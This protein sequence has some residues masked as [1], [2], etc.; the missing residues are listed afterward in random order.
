LASVADFG[1]TPAPGVTRRSR[2]ATHGAANAVAQRMLPQKLRTGGVE[3]SN[4]ADRDVKL[5]GTV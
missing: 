2:R 5:C 3:A 4:A 1:S